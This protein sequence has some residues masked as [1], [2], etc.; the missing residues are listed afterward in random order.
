MSSGSVASHSHQSVAHKGTPLLRNVTPVEQDAVSRMFRL[1]D[2]ELKGNIPDYLARNLMNQL[3]F[4]I[5]NLEAVFGHEVSLREVLLLLDQMIPD[6]DPSKALEGGMATF[7]GLVAKERYNEETDEVTRVLTPVDISTFMESL[8]RP[9][10]SVSEA[11]L[12]LNSMNDYDD[13]AE[14]PVLQASV[15]HKEVMLFAKKS[16][17]LREFEK[18]RNHR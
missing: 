16:N 12:M 5:M 11:T 8:G 4:H 9:A 13:V 2:H 6:P 15:F 1:Y 14:V 18:E 17:C 3:G 10:A 7:N